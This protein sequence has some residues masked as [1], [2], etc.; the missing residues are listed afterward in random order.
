MR[1]RW[2]ELPMPTA[3]IDRVNVLGRTERSLLVFTDCQ[4]RVIGDYAPTS[5]EQ[6]DVDNVGGAS[7]VHVVLEIYVKATAVSNWSMSMELV[8]ILN[9]WGDWE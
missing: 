3:V 4:G 8:N 7:N 9:S 1:N 6:A 5:V 2:K